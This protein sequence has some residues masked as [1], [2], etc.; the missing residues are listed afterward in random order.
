MYVVWMVTGGN[1]TK[2]LGRLNSSSGYFTSSLEG[3]LST[4]TPFK[5]DYVYITAENTAAIQYP[6]GA[7]VLSTR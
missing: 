5:P 1:I 6:T 2:N 7:V 3:T 4:V